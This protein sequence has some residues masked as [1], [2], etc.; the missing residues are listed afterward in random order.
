MRKLVF[1]LFVVYASIISG[2][3]Y[4]LFTDYWIDE[5]GYNFGVFKYCANNVTECQSVTN[6]LHTGQ[7]YLLVTRYTLISACVFGSLCLLCCVFS[8]CESCRPCCK[9]AKMFARTNVISTFIL[10]VLETC[11][12][13]SFMLALA[14]LPTSGSLTKGWSFYVEVLSS[15]FTAFVFFILIFSILF[16]NKKYCLDHTAFVSRSSNEKLHF[17]KPPRS[18]NVDVGKSVSVTAEVLNADNVYWCKGR[19]HVI[20]YSTS[21]TEHFESPKAE[22]KIQNTRLQDEGEYTCVAEKYGK[23]K[24]KRKHKF[25]IYVF[26]V[27]PVFTKKPENVT[28]HVGSVL[29]LEAKVNNAESVTWTHNGKELIN[30]SKENIELNFLH[31]EAS[32]RIGKVTTDHDGDY[33]CTARSGNDPQKAKKDFAHCNVRVVNAELP[34]FEN[35]P[36]SKN[37]KE[38]DILEIELKVCGFPLPEKVSWFKGNDRLE[39]NKR[40][41]MHYIEGKSKL[42][43][44]DTREADS[45]LYECYTE[46]IH[47]NNVCRIPVK[48]TKDGQSQERI[49]CPICM[50]RRPDKV[51]Q[52]GHVFCSECSGRFTECPNCRAPVQILTSL[53]L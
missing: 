8:M 48:V 33:K 3:F 51:L 30:S 23:N 41:T 31:G 24:A 29:N 14:K 20:K 16:C 50:D 17:T 9:K 46:N 7:D 43:I 45:G 38:G 11:T 26:H 22:L 32:L 15:I 18:V 34:S 35:A 1:S 12:V 47:G 52:C 4:A 40:I 28:V 36:G 25:S 37:I 13:V 39:M 49:E 10:I 42:A 53:F 2:L 44:Q 6:E 21:F 27:Q 5:T 19:D